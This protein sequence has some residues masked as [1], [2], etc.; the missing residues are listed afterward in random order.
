MTKFMISGMQGKVY[1]THDDAESD[2]LRWGAHGHIF[3]VSDE[4]GEQ[5]KKERADNLARARDRSIFEEKKRLNPFY[6]W[7][8]PVMGHSGADS[9]GYRTWWAPRFR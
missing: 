7:P 3:G 6:D 9:G 4:M 1:D 8:R 5:F 2:R